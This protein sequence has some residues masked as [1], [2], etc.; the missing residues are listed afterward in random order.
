MYVKT[1]GKYLYAV[2]N[3]IVDGKQKSKS[4]GRI[5]EEDAQ[6]IN[7][8]EIPEKLQIEFEEWYNNTIIFH[9]RHRENHVKDFPSDRE[10]DL[11]EQIKVLKIR[12]EEQQNQVLELKTKA[13]KYYIIKQLMQDIE[14]KKLE[15]K[16]SLRPKRWVEEVLQPILDGE[17]M[18]L[19]EKR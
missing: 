13:S 2:H 7:K 17:P 18:V 5:S 9:Y 3:F 1:V 19:K 10:K 16:P 8:G 4:F 12:L 11:K 6:L 14:S 15:N